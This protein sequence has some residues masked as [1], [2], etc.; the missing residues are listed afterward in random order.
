MSKRKVI[1]FIVSTFES[2][3]ITQVLYNKCRNLDYSRFK[4]HIL[5][6]SPEPANTQI[7]KFKQIPVHLHSLNLSRIEALFFLK[8]Q[9]KNLVREINPDFIHTYTYRPS[10]YAWKFLGKYKRIVTLSSNLE[11]NYQRTYGKLLG[12]YIAKKEFHAFKNADI[13]TVVSKTLAGIY[14]EIP[15]IHVIQNGADESVFF[16]PDS[17]LKLNLRKKLHL[18]LNAKIYIS[19]G[20]LSPL[21]DPETVLKAFLQKEKNTNEILLFLG[22]GSELEKLKSMANEQVLFLGFKNNPHEYLQAADVFVSASHSE[23]L[24]NTVVEAAACGLK[25][26]LSD[27]SQHREIFPENGHQAEFFPIGNAKLLSEL[28]S[29]QDYGFADKNFLLTAKRMTN[30]YMELYEKSMVQN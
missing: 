20:A 29:G 23:G 15:N 27:I 30:A 24:P 2:G 10:Y 21:K 22:E 17:E 25:C 11:P 26:L 7:D 19:V 6:L 8:S 4:V 3:G 18:D 16:M 28:M 14:K 13:K 9:L 1:L 12:S 5:S